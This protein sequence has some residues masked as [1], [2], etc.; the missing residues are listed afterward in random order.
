MKEREKNKFLVKVKEY[1]VTK[2]EEEIIT[3]FNEICLDKL[4]DGNTD[5][6][7]YPI[8]DLNKKEFST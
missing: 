1:L 6:D 8:Y 2:S 5:K 4:F 7:S 3:L